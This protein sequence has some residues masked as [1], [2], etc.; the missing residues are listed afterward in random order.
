MTYIQ[1]KNIIFYQENF[2]KNYSVKTLSIPTFYAIL[3]WKSDSPRHLPLFSTFSNRLHNLLYTPG[4]CRIIF[5][6][7]R[8]VF[9]TYRSLLY[10]CRSMFHTYRGLL[11]KCRSEVHTFRSLFDTCRSLLH[12]YRSLLDTCRSL[13]H[14]YRS[15]LYKCT[16]ANG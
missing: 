2:Y 1:N 4:K 16:I 8:C 7:C 10:K 14:T 3:Y 6:K 9:H 5:D 13:F 15:L 11:D 12:T